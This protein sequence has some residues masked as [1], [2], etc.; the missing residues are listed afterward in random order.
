MIEKLAHPGN[1]HTIDDAI[2]FLEKVPEHHLVDADSY[3]RALTYIRD[4]YLERGVELRQLHRKIEV[5]RGTR[6]V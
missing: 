3:K 4:A 6:F 2:E 5:E 1:F